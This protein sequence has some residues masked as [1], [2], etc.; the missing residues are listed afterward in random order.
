MV[1]TTVVEDFQGSKVLTSQS[2]DVFRRVWKKLYA[3]DC[4][5]RVSFRCPFIANSKP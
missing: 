5:A 3:G 1:N 4:R 2:Q